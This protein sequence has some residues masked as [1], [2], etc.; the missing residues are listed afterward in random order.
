MATAY[1]LTEVGRTGLLLLGMTGSG[2]APAPGRVNWYC[3]GRGRRPLVF[4]PAA[5]G[6]YQSSEFSSGAHNQAEAGK[7]YRSTI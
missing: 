2:T 7:L 5:P 1:P 3:L 4:V 6:S